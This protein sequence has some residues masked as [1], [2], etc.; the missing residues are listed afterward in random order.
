M[1]LR[2]A[3]AWFEKPSTLYPAIPVEVWTVVMSS[4]IGRIAD[5]RVA[6]WHISSFF[7]AHP[8]YRKLPFAKMRVVQ[9]AIAHGDYCCLGDGKT[10]RAVA[11]WRRI[12]L[13]EMLQVY[14]QHVP[15]GSEPKDVIFVSSLAAID[16]ASLKIMVRHIKTSFSDKDIYWDR[17]SGKLGHRP[18]KLF[19]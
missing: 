10:I 11:M 3:V 17:H 6:F 13:A 14:P 19:A 5:S 18:A 16:R 2:A 4:K 8:S 15:A 12:K 1:W 7:M 9:Q